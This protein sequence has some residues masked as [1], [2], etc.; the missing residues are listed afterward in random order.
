VNSERRYI[1]RKKILSKKGDRVEIAGHLSG[2]EK[3]IE[4]KNDVSF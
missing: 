2:F 4:P 1:I 3:R